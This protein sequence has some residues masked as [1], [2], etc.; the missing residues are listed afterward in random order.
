MTKLTQ[1]IDA[2]R[3]Y[4]KAIVAFVAPGAVLIGNAVTERSPGGTAIT[5]DEWVVALV[6]CVVA[7]GMVYR[8]PNRQADPPPVSADRKRA[9]DFDLITRDDAPKRTPG[10]PPAPPE[11]TCGVCG[12][13]LKPGGPFCH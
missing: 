4:A 11:I 2:L 8:V 6:A 5:A 9:L 13:E 10:P 7:S 3:P 12:G 1:A